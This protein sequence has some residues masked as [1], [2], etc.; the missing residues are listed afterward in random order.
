MA[1]MAEG[2]RKARIRLGLAALAGAAALTLVLGPR[3]RFEGGWVEPR[4]GG[5]VEAFLAEREAGV[6]G[7]RP[8]EAKA[9]VWIDAARREPTPVSIVYLHGFSADR[10]ETDPLVGGLAEAL[11][12]NVYFTRLAG[13]GQDGAAMGEARTADWLADV[14]EAI[15]VGARIGRSVVLMGTSTGG[16]LALWAAAQPEAAERVA[17]L[18]LV[19]PN[20]GLRDPAS[21][22]LTWP[23]GGLIARLAVGSERCFQ[24]L[25]PAQ[26]EHWTECYPTRALLP[27]GALVKHVASM[28]F[29]SVRV[30]TL[31]VYSREDGVVDPEVTRRVLAG[32]GGGTGPAYFEVLHSDD[33]Q[34]H[35][36]AG[37]ILSPGSTGE[38]RRAVLD[39][40]ALRVAPR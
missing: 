18:V 7:L 8:G 38:V 31:V 11:G 32:L 12:A 27:M 5:D 3:A 39:F 16:T 21:R 15:A 26:A 23:W 28:D 6:R 25:N 17:A 10:H 35:V 14:S 13:H 2:T 40:L 4:L 36:L 30:P 22:V 37:S 20:L 33:P 24:P 34:R 19:S 1:D 9:V 29:S